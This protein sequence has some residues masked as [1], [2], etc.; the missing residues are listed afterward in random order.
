MLDGHR[1]PTDEINLEIVK[2][3]T[4][5]GVLALTTRT[6]LLQ[7]I[8]FVAFAFYGAFFATAQFGTY[9]IVLAARNFL[10][11]FS[12]IGLAG[13]LI[14]KKDRLEDSDLKT[15]FLIQQVLVILLLVVLYLLTPTLISYYQLTREGVFLLWAFGLSLFLSSLKTIPSVILERKLEFTKLIIPQI[16]EAIVFN[17]LV[18]YLA[19]QG[20]GL[21]SFTIAVIAQGVIGLVIL[22]YLCPWVPGVAFSKSSLKSLLKFGVPYQLNTF[23]AMVKDDGLTLVLGSILGPAGIGLLTW[24]QKWGFAPLR[25]FMDQVIK[26]TFPAYARLQDNKEELGKAVGRSIFFICFLVFPS[27]VGLV[28]LSPLLITIVPRYSQWEP[29]LLAL[30]FFAVNAAFAAVSTPLTNLFNAIGKI[31]VTFKL[32]IMWTVL[33]WAIMPYLAIKYS[34]TGAALG[35]A[36]VSTSSIVVIYLARKYISFNFLTSVIKPLLAAIGMGVILFITRGMMA[37][38]IQWV[39]VLVVFG[40]LTYLLGIILLVGQSVI[41]DIRKVFNATLRKK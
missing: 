31:S 11:Y 30:S 29:A 1:D 17:G 16:V 2:T 35:S 32:M 3:R 37:P 5:S 38:S 33:S 28:I 21:T 41:T 40:S 19:S 34:V 24:A 6:M 4:V 8:S 39:L 20:F 26:V 22:Y 13:A 12:D 25:F 27:L 9:A 23:L 36:L 18:I 15:T 14:Q 10:G 7:I